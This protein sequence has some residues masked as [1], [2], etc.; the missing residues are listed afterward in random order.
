M[1]NYHPIIRGE[2]VMRELVTAIYEKGL[3]RPLSPLK[4]KEKQTVFLQIVPQGGD[5]EVDR[6]TAELVLAGALTLPEPIGEDDEYITD[7]ELEL[8]AAEVGSQI[9]KPLSEIIIEERE[10]SW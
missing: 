5:E 7:E 10:N 2:D 4:L 1:Q 3:L 9:G 8:L 6:L